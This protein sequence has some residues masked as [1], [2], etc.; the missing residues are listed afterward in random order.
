MTKEVEKIADWIGEARDRNKNL[1]DAHENELFDFLMDREGSKRITT[2]QDIKCSC[3]C[4]KSSK[5]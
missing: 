4:K 3:T 5:M 1:T 2:L